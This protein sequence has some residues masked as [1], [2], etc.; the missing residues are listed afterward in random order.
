MSSDKSILNISEVFSKIGEKDDKGKKKL[1]VELE[2]GQKVNLTKNLIRLHA[3]GGNY[4]CSECGCNGTHLQRHLFID[5]TKKTNTPQ[6]TEVWRMM[7][8][9]NAGQCISY[10]NIDHIIPKSKGGTYEFDNIRVTCEYCNSRRQNFCTPEL[11]DAIKQNWF[12]NRK[13]IVECL[14]EFIKSSIKKWT[15]QWTRRLKHFFVIFD[16]KFHS[17]VF[18]K[19]LNPSQLV[20]IV[21]T[22]FLSI[23]FQHSIDEQFF[24]SRVE[25]LSR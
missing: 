23:N 13:F 6:Y 2:S 15:K 22:C 20:E 5:N 17:K 21:N 11:L 25:L 8:W 24:L 9:S 14:K 19:T 7:T 18:K 1:Y 3:L 4:T 12:N 10:L 16:S